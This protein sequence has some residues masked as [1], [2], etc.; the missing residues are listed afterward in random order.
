M[1]ETV[2]VEFKFKIGEAVK[3]KNDGRAFIIERQEFTRRAND[4]IE[5]WYYGQDG[6]VE[7]HLTCVPEDNL[8]KLALSGV[9][10]E[11]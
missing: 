11:L 2:T 8:I 4:V 6:V 7:H 5:I 1:S 3:R 9:R 10:H